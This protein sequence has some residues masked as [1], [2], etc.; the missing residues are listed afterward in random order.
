MYEKNQEGVDDRHASG[1][2]RRAAYL[3]KSLSGNTTP[4]I[5]TIVRESCVLRVR[6]PQI[7]IVRFRGIA[8]LKNSGNR[9][10]EGPES[11]PTGRPPTY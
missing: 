11:A 2:P 1:T 3:A 7:L 9:D 6:R 10:S 5:T 8:D 4:A